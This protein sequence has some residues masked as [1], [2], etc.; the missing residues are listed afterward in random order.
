MQ[1]SYGIGHE[2]VPV[3]VSNLYVILLQFLNKPVLI[4]LNKTD[5]IGLR[6]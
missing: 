4:K 1:L 6:M 5:K 2:L 3:L